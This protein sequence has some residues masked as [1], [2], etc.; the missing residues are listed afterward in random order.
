MQ[1]QAAADQ[2]ALLQW[3]GKVA[4]RSTGVVVVAGTL[5]CPYWELIRHCNAGTQIVL[6]DPD[7]TDDFAAEKAV[8]VACCTTLH[9][10]RGLVATRYKVPLRCEVIGTEPIQKRYG[11]EVTALV[12][13]TIKGVWEAEHTTRVNAQR[14]AHLGLVALEQMIGRP[15]LNGLAPCLAGRT[16]VIVGAGPSL[17]RNI[18]ALAAN[19]DRVA[20][21]ATDAS[22]GPLYRAGIH[23]HVVV[24]VEANGE[25]TAKTLQ[26]PLW[27][28]AVVIPGVH[29]AEHVWKLRPLRWLWGV[30]MVGSVGPFVVQTMG[31]PLLRSGGSVSTIAYSAAQ[32]MGADR[33]VLV[34]M[35]SAYAPDGRFY[36]GKVAHSHR[37]SKDPI[38]KCEAWGGV[39]YVDAPRAM[40]SYRE[41][42]EARAAEQ[43]ALGRPLINAT[44]GGA[45]I[46]DAEETRLVEALGALPVDASVRG[47][48]VA[49]VDGARTVEAAPIVEGLRAELERARIAAVFAAEAGEN[50]WRAHSRIETML[51]LPKADILFRASVGPIQETGMMPR[52]NELLAASQILRRVAETQTTLDGMIRATVES[53]ERTH[54]RAS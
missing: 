16:A 41:W 48:I 22:V 4:W 31:L 49:A 23:P 19:Q 37:P 30:Q 21:F 33:V 42:F 6:F 34:G 10:L 18:D 26:N 45:R 17:D 43:A 52:G 32:V 25:P 44:E 36:A 46:R 15:V 50:M 39:G 9:E 20:I 1:D 24:T 28:E 13:T 35:D 53:I 27:R 54:G 11:E 3:A 2:A 38:S 7:R 12:D 40:C 8:G 14:W 29:V 5:Q 51:G 47:D